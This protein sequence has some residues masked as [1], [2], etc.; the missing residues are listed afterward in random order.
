MSHWFIDFLM[1]GPK[2]EPKPEPEPEPKPVWTYIGYTKFALEMMQGSDTT[3]H[4]I[5]YRIAYYLGDKG[6]R[7]FSVFGDE[8]KQCRSY[9]EKHCHEYTDAILWKEGGPFP[10]NF[11]PERDTLG[12]MLNRLVTERLMGEE[13][14]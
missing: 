6:E 8:D 5:P 4:I 7:K 11:K 2:P 14:K 9:L 3:K 12:A 13:E 10:D 1:G